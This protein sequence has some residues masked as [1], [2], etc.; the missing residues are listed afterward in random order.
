MTVTDAPPMLSTGETETL[1]TGVDREIHRLC[2]REA[3]TALHDG[4]PGLDARVHSALCGLGVQMLAV[5]AGHG[6]IAIDHNVLGQVFGRLAARGV[7]L[8]L[9]ES[10]VVL[11]GLLGEVSPDRRAAAILRG[12]AEEG[13]LTTLALGEQ[14][15]DLPGHPIGTVLSE[16]SEGLRL[17]GKKRMVARAAGAQDCVVLARRDPGGDAVLV[18]LPAVQA[19]GAV[20][21]THL[22]FVGRSHADMHFDRL[23]VA[24]DMVLD[25]V[26]LT[27]SRLDRALALGATLRAMEMTAAAGTA[28][29]I[30]VDHTRE[31]HQFGRPIGAFQAVQHHCVDMLIAVE[32]ALA[33]CRDALATSNTGDATLMWEAKAWAN[34]ACRQTQRLA[35][36]VMGGLGYMEEHDLPN[37]FR[38][39][40]HAENSL[41]APGEA[42]QAAFRARYG[43]GGRG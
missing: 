25:G 10:W 43:G 13:R 21:R 3:V 15:S 24:P 39:L 35:H 4:A 2:P 8:P 31:R 26:E 7:A 9:V 30:A 36:Q 29:R 1:L 17:D 6:G 33:L 11:P 27:P 38:F 19:A 14:G 28:M 34:H 42:E 12:I 22:T 20:T 37:L 23:P 5:G 41:G 18:H 40:R 16:T 32:T